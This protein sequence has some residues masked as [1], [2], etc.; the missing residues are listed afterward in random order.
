MLT[1]KMTEVSI[2][3]QRPENP[4]AGDRVYR[5]VKYVEPESPGCPPIPQYEL[6]EAEIEMYDDGDA[7]NGPSVGIT[8][9]PWVLLGSGCGGFP[10]D[11]QEAL[12]EFEAYKDVEEQV[13]RELLS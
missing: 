6:F 5:L 7:E 3:E 1:I 2:E 13:A 9:G 8:L 11:V 4:T 12:K 10:R